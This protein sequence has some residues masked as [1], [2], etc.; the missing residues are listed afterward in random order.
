MLNFAVAMEEGGVVGDRFLHELLEQ[1]QLG[2]VDDG[3]DAVLNASIG[4]KV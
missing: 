1:E 2:A 4:V 3:V